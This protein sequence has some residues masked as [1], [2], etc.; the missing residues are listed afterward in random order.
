MPQL[1]PLPQATGIPGELYQRTY[2]FCTRLL[3][4]P[5]PYC[6]VALDCAVRLKTETAVPGESCQPAGPPCGNTSPSQGSGLFLLR[7]LR[8]S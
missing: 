7:D 4:L 1:P 8:K 5:T 2:A 3:T 6:T